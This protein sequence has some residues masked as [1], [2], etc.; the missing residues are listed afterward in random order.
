MAHDQLA[1]SLTFTP[2]SDMKSL[3]SFCQRGE[4]TLRDEEE[5]EQ[6]LTR[7]SG[8]KKRRR[9]AAGAERRRRRVLLATPL[10]A[11]PQ[12]NPPGSARVC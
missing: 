8:A 4:R 9:G 1:V 3:I 10:T 5:K 6:S 11:E 7:R 12:N 2:P